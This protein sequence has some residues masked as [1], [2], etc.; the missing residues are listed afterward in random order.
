MTA[1]D[2]G[3]TFWLALLTLVLTL[4][5]AMVANDDSAESFL[6]GISPMGDLAF[7]YSAF[8]VDCYCDQIL[9]G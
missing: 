1:Q 9:D 4:V 6:K 7:F 8:R 3:L 5:S 2:L